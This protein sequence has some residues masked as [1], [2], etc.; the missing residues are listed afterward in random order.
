M[1]KLSS[2]PARAPLSG[3]LPG[4]TPAPAPG[5]HNVFLIMLP[6]TLSVFVSFLTIGLPLPVLPLHLHYTLGLS[7]VVVGVVMGA[8][9]AAA[10]LSRA[11][12]GGR[13]DTSGAKRAMIGGCMVATASGAFYLASLA[14]TVMPA[15]SAGVLL[16][17]RICLGC[18][19]S[20]IITGA[21][22]WGVILAGPHNTGKVMAWVG[23]AM[24]AAYAVGAP[25]GTLIYSPYGF[26]GISA[27]TIAIPLLALAVVARTRGVPATAARRLPFYKVLGAVWLPGI[28][29]TLCSVGLGVMTTFI[30]LLFAAKGWGSA[31]LAFTTFGVAFIGV[32]LLFAHLPDKIGGGKVALV[33]V[34]VEALG[35]LLIW[36]ADHAL[37]AYLGAGLTGLGFSL[38]FP[39]FG[40]EAVRGAPPQSRGAA[41]GAFV[42]FLD[43]S[44]GITGPAAGAIAGGYG[45]SAVYLAGAVVVACS[46]I[47]A[48]MLIISPPRAAV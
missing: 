22:S 31:S 29:L 2:A 20:L 15:L 32:R 43:L 24:Y 36:Q 21:L 14:F 27:A 34:L 7:T 4:S 35:L 9:F 37:T 23:M 26:A 46:A 12:A 10:L 3:P 1:T 5:E 13:A 18:G 19:E 39:G 8:Q 11:W 44:L 16:L 28:G 40:V 17:G 33:C 30:A 6:I 41:M 42:A 38:A 25:L 45:V 48:V 47:V